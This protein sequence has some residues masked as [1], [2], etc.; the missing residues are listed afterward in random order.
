MERRDQG[1]QPRVA[2]VISAAEVVEDRERQ[3]GARI[4]QGVAQEERSALGIGLMAQSSEHPLAAGQ[5]SPQ[6]E[7]TL[8]IIEVIAGFQ[9]QQTV[10]GQ[11]LGRQGAALPPGGQR[12]IQGAADSLDA[13]RCAC[14]RKGKRASVRKQGRWT[15][16]TGVRLD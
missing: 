13:G 4:E 6:Q 3:R 7:G 10:A 12:L 5:G 16:P 1:G 8:G 2:V 9:H 14:A 15:W 11:A